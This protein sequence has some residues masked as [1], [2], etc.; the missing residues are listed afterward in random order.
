MTITH[1][2]YDIFCGLIIVNDEGYRYIIEKK[3]AQI[4]MYGLKPLNGTTEYYKEAWI[5]FVNNIINENT[6]INF[7]TPD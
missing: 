1:T 7:I 4:P 2:L 5:Y 6:T 3:S